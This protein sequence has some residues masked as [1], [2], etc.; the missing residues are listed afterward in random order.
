MKKKNCLILTAHGVEY[1]GKDTKPA[2]IDGKK[3]TI[4]KNMP[5]IR[6][7]LVACLDWQYAAVRH[8][9]SRYLTC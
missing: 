5:H 6:F 2:T 8:T 7:G 3:N 1:L 9:V 4:I